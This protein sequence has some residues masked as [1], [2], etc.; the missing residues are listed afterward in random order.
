MQNSASYRPQLPVMPSQQ[1]S[2]RRLIVSRPTALYARVYPPRSKTQHM[3]YTNSQR[4]RM[5]L[6]YHKTFYTGLRKHL[7]RL[8]AADLNAFYS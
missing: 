1:I 5:A 8:E 3:S 2:R 7:K 4:L 6:V